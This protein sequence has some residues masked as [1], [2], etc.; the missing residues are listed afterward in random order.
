MHL[1]KTF[2]S[3]ETILITLLAADI[4]LNLISDESNQDCPFPPLQDTLKKKSKLFHENTLYCCLRNLEG[5]CLNG[6]DT[7]PSQILTEI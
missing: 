7:T 6:S 4:I 2:F 3:A 1:H 5:I